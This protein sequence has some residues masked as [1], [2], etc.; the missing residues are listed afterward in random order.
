MGISHYIKTIIILISLIAGCSFSLFAEKCFNDRDLYDLKGNVKKCVIKTKSPIASDTK[1]Q[2]L[3]SG[4]LK[5]NTFARTR[6]GKVLGSGMAGLGNCIDL[7]IE[8]NAS[9]KPLKFVESTTFGG[10]QTTDIENIYDGELL[11]GRNIKISSKKGITKIV[12]DYSNEIVDSNGNWT[13]RNVK[14]SIWKPGAKTPQITS[15]TEQ[16]DICY[17]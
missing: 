2:F 8:Y 11:K 5:N 4:E 9:G 1:P 7:S 12:M 17:Y 3:T 14:Q 15:Y 6:C 10:G 16:R 13:S